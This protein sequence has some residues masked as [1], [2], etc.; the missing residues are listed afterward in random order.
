MVKNTACAN[1]RL[2]IIF[3]DTFIVMFHISKYLD[4]L[5]AVFIT[6]HLIQAQIC[7][8]KDCFLNYQDP[9]T[10]VSVM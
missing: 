7:M 6:Q 8:A 10:P 9:I 4:D 2:Q 1:A 5:L 3:M